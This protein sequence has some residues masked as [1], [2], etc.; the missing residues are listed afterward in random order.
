M[1]H[2]DMAATAVSS[3]HSNLHLEASPRGSGHALYALALAV[4]KASSDPA[5]SDLLTSAFLDFRILRRLDGQ[6]NSLAD[7]PSTDIMEAAKRRFDTDEPDVP[8]YLVAASLSGSKRVH[9][10]LRRLDLTPAELAALVA[11]FRLEQKGED[12]VSPRVL[13]GTLI[14]A[15]FGVLTS[16]LLFRA[17]SDGDHWWK[18]VFLPAIW[19]GYPQNGALASMF[20]AAVLGV[21]VSPVVGLAHAIGILGD[22]AHARAERRSLLARTG[23]RVSLTETRRIRRRLL[24][25]RA[26]RMSMGL[27]FGRVSLRARR[28]GYDNPLEDPDD[29]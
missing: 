23:V 13:Y 22:I 18:L 20:V 16:V 5:W 25:K 12:D 6:L 19:A 4:Q 14:N 27:Q 28:G 3:A 29:S 24:S 9:E 2:P 1:S 10:A 11:E 21:V 7:D 15:L 26:R 8:A 17:A